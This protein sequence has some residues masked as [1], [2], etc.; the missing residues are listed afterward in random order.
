MAIQVIR[1]FVCMIF[2]A[3]ALTPIQ[4][5]ADDAAVLPKGLWRLL[6]TSEIAFNWSERYNPNGDKEPLATDFNA[7]LNRTVFPA[8]AALGPT[9]TL[10][11]SEVSFKRGATVTV[12][13]PA[14]GVTDRLSVGVNIPYWTV[15]N[16]VSANLNAASATVGKNVA[17]DGLRPLSVPGTVRLTTEDV[18]KILGGGLDVNG[19]GD[20]NVAGLGFKPLRNFSWSGVGD[21]EVGARYQYYRGQNFRAAFT[22]GVSLP[23]GRVD[24]PDNLA[25]VGIGAGTYGVLF[26]FNQDLL[27]QKE[28]L[29][30]RLG[31]PEPGDSLINTTFRYDL[32]LPD[33]QTMRIC[34]PNFPLCSAKE[35]VKRDLGDILEAEIQWRVGL[36]FRGLIFSALYKYGHN[37]KDH[38]SGNRGLNY[39]VL[40]GE[41]DYTEHMY[42]FGL[43]YSTIPGIRGSGSKLPPFSVSVLYRNRFAGTN[44]PANDTVTFSVNYF[45]RTPG[46]M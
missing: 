25:D 41:S 32:R 15:E 18:Q 17:A 4:S 12:F 35:D 16:R 36:F 13:Q 42:V 9:A 29:G 46:L 22:G 37:F 31:F 26:Q 43:T 39:G 8:L 10:G 45:F 33:K 27:F 20:I 5:H 34:D 6:A 40:T 44:T 19:D 24:D 7:N 23:T 11:R 3:I 1:T 21:I 2:L 14:Y 30:K 38:I 28:G